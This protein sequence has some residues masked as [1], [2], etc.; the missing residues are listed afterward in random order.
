MGL[1][2]IRILNEFTNE[3]FHV[4][5]NPEEY[6]L[7]KDNSFSSQNVLGL[8]GPVQQFLHGNLRTLDMELFFDT[9]ERPDGPDRDVRTE[10]EKVTN[11]LK[12]DSNLHAPPVLQLSWGSLQ[13]RCLLARV[14]QRFTMFL[15]DGR[16][17]RARLT[18]TFNEFI[19]PE[20]E[21]KAINRQTA[22][23]TK[24]HT[25]TVGELISSIAQRYYDDP[26]VWRPIAIANNL[27]NPRS[28][29]AGQALKIPSLPFVDLAT[30]EE[31]R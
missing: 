2:K 17:V 8:S 22:D 30:G 31:F 23:F 11:L 3:H 26:Q 10:T 12:I 25:V 6:T 27:D 19:D 15:E 21:A 9:Y 24:I 14:N 18:V 13:F 28:I 7:S 1:E 16:P 20:R 29:V 5:F 4:M